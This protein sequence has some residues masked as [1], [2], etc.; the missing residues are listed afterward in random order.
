MTAEARGS[1]GDDRY[2]T[3]VRGF[4]FIARVRFTPAGSYG[5]RL[6]EA[7]CG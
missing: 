6:L 2:K 5:T 3:T 1:R 4:F 7:A